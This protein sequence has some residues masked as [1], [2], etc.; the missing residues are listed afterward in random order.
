MNCA[1]IK[2]L[3]SEYV[4]GV[5]DAQTRAGI[6]EHIATCVRCQKEIKELKVLVEDLGSLKHAKAPDDFIDRLH[7]RIET[8]FGFGRIINTLFVP[9][10]FKIP[11]QIVTAT[12]TAVLVFSII[13]V[14][15]PEKQFPEK[16]LMDATT[17][18]EKEEI[19]PERMKEPSE[20]LLEKR[21]YSPKPVSQKTVAYKKSKTKKI[22]DIAL[23]ELKTEKIIE[24]ALVLKTD[25]YRKPSSKI[26]PLKAAPPAE[27]SQM[28]DEE[29]KT[30]IR[31]S[32]QSR[33]AGKAA[34]KKGVVAGATKKDKKAETPLPAQPSALEEKA[35]KPKL[36]L[37]H[38]TVKLR[39][40]VKDLKGEIKAIQYD[41]KTGHPIFLS[42]V[43]PFDKYP[44]F[45]K[46]LKD[47]GDFHGPLPAT[48]EK[49]EEKKKEMI[50]IKL[51]I[52]K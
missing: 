9:M 7:E 30:S 26:T 45:Y 15:Q 14:Q 35:G 3:L 1:G 39:K 51:V 22:G 41:N 16:S 23:K 27:I 17:I 37:D 33:M 11:V 36:G 19:K 50:Q 18:S 20:P 29:E 6:K 5:L 25:T 2:E 52:S 48:E 21:K 44:V 46:K 24:L 32:L 13:H 40:I 47:M 28:H 42:A 38:I 49:K 31:P 4:D 10:R 43:I 8:R 12:A 34:T